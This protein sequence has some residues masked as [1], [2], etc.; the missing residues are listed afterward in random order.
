MSDTHILAAQSTFPHDQHGLAKFRLESAR[1]MKEHDCHDR[2]A[3][4]ATAIELSAVYLTSPNGGS[5]G[6]A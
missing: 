1:L 3:V 5:L 2:Q 6:T 4:D